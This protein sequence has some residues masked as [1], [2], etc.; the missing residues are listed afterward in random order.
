MQ[1]SYL[2]FDLVILDNTVIYH[3]VR[4]EVESCLDCMIDDSDPPDA[5]APE[6]I[7]EKGE[8]EESQPLSIGYLASLSIPFDCLV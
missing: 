6:P 2:C 3:G 4:Q 8:E 5:E 1:R 7:E